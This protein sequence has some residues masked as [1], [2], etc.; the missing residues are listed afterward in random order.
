MQIR[1]RGIEREEV[2][3]AAARALARQGLSFVAAQR[4]PS[5][6]ADWSDCCQSIE[7]AA[8]NDAEQSRIASFVSSAA[9]G[10]CAQANSTPEAS[11]SPR[12]VG[13]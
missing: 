3:R 7:R 8:Q 10:I 6:I 11:R 13:V 12:R 2:R 1:H 4:H 9:F 5:G